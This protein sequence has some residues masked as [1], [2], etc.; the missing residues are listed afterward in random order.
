MKKANRK[1]LLDL[2]CLTKGRSSL[3]EQILTDVID[4]YKGKK[5]GFLQCEAPYSNLDHALAVALAGGRIIDGCRKCG[6]IVIEAEVAFTVFVACLL[7]DVGMLRREDDQPGTTEG[8]LTFRHVQ[9]SLDFGSK[10][11]RSLELD[12]TIVGGVTFAIAN[13]ALYKESDPL[14][15]AR[16]EDMHVAAIVASADLLAQASHPNILTAM[17]H[18]WTELEAAYGA[19]SPEYLKAIGAPRFT[20]YQDLLLNILEF[21]D[22]VLLPKLEEAGGFHRFLEH[23]FGCRDH[24]FAR[25]IKDNCEILAQNRSIL[26]EVATRLFSARSVT[27]LKNAALPHLRR[28][29]M[30]EAI[31]VAARDV[32]L[33]DAKDKDPGLG[34]AFEK[35]DYQRLT[36]LPGSLLLTD[37]EDLKQ[38]GDGM[39]PSFIAAMYPVLR[40]GAVLLRTLRDRETSSTGMIALLSSTESRSFPNH[41]LRLLEDLES[42][43]IKAVGGVAQTAPRSRARIRTG[44]KRIL[45]ASGRID[46]A[47]FERGIQESLRSAT[48]LPLVLEGL[49]GLEQ[50]TVARALAETAGYDFVLLD[51]STAKGLGDHLQGI[52]PKFCRKHHVVPFASRGERVQVAAA[53]PVFQDIQDLL[54]RLG[55][56]RKVDLRI[57]TPK[58]ITDFILAAFRSEATEDE[59]LRPAEIESLTA[60]ASREE[61]PVDANGSRQVSPE[62]NIIVRLAEKILLDAIRQHGS[63]IHVEYYPRRGQGKVRIRVDGRMQHHLDLKRRFLRPL[64][65]RYKVLA[66]LDIAE[67]RLPQDGRLRLQHQGGPIDVRIVTMPRSDGFEDV[68]LRILQ[69]DSVTR[70]EDLKFTG[71]NLETWKRVLIAP[72]GLIVVCGPTGSGKTTTIHASIGHIK[73]DAVKI[74]TAEDPVEIVQDG[75]SQVQVVPARSFGFAEA[76]KAFL[77]ADPDVIFVGEIRDGETAKTAVRASLTGHLVL[78]TLHSGT[79]VDALVRLSHNGITGLDLSESL[80]CALAQR[81][82]RRLCPHCAVPANPAAEDAIIQDGQQGA[83]STKLL[84]ASATGCPS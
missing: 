75:I 53:D 39:P 66:G 49:A 6:K 68:V 54:R 2:Y 63:D 9:R 78:S 61:T 69:Q 62:D 77:R 24:P 5:G 38:L 11:L 41:S 47:T 44:L 74:W 73:H 13:T 55:R 8:T 67:R 21:F 84:Q 28:L 79:A 71:Q 43:V 20:S 23:H 16:P 18:L 27:E 30:A 58:N 3:A 31:V 35:L 81:L 22:S 4:F 7:H 72:H 56:N 59:L 1:Q 50:E 46:N 51:L 64:A 65:A 26:L 32:L 34:A 17:S 33:L 70:V 48:P 29:L 76:L 12:E 14:G 15:P 57:A 80:R 52:N 10:Y 19:E 45:A 25:A 82:V 36:R 60:D 83:K 40:Q 37:I 42:A